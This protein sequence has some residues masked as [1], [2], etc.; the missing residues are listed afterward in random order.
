MHT[1]VTRPRSSIPTNI[2]PP[3][4][5]NMFFMKGGVNLRGMPNGNVPSHTHSPQKE[6][7]PLAT[8]VPD[9]IC[10]K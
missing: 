6:H 8:P 5:E 1:N 3:N 9:L 7:H 2:D 4:P 10:L